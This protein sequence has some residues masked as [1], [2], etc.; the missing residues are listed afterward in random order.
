MFS[1]FK[2]TKGLFFMVNWKKMKNVILHIELP[3]TKNQINK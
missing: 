3:K 1:D 2:G